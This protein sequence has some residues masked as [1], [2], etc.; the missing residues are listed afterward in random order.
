M[1][2][3]PL[4]GLGVSSQSFPTY[5]LILASPHDG[6]SPLLSLGLLQEGTA[7][8]RFFF[9]RHL[10]D[11]G[12]TFSAF[13]SASLLLGSRLHFSRARYEG[14]THKRGEVWRNRARGD[15]GT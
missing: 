6:A 4:P 7:K 9:H 5:E 2:P 1:E 14:T 12:A 15:L 3:S 13:L 11:R 8:V 10:R